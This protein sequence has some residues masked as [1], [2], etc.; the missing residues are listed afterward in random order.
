MNKWNRFFLACGLLFGLI[1]QAQQKRVV[2]P[3]LILSE[4]VQS[5]PRGARQ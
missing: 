5:M 4:I 2:R 1:A 3:Q